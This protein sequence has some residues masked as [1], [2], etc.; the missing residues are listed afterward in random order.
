MNIC[1]TVTFI[2]MPSGLKIPFVNTLHWLKKYSSKPILYVYFLLDICVKCIKSYHGQG[3]NR[4]K[5]NNPYRNE[6][7]SC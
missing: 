1:V 2:H 7:E 6:S 4:L 3:E 5:T